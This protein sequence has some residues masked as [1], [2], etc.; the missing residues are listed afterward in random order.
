MNLPWISIITM[1]P[2][3]G[4]ALVFCL[5]RSRPQWHKI[6]TFA[7][8]LLVLIFSIPLFT[9]FCS[10]S[11]FQFVE[12]RPL[13]PGFGIE[14]YLG[15]DGI[16]L[17]LVLLVTFLSP[18]VVLS[19]W[20]YI[21]HQT[22]EY[23]ACLLLLQCGMTGALA[24]MDTFLFYVFWELMLVPMFFI[25]GIWGGPRR[26]YA[27]IKFVLFTLVGSL[28]MLIGIIYL[29]WQVHDQLGIRSFSILDFFK[30]QLDMGEQ[31]W[32]FGAFALAFAIKV[33]MFPFH[34]WLPDAHV[35][36][37]TGGSVIL[38]G[39]LLKMGT[40]G[41]L[42]FVLPLFPAASHFFAPLMIILA[43]IG[44]IYGALVSLVQDDVKKLVAYSSVSHLGYVMLGIF[45]FSV[46]GIQGGIFQMLSHGL[47]T[48]A[49]F[50]I[51]GMLYERRHTRQIEEFGGLCRTLPRLAV[52]FMVTVLASAGLPGLS[53]F[54]GEFLI[55]LAAFKA[56]P[57]WGALAGTGIILGA[58]YLLWM[59]QRVMFGP[60]KKAEN[61]NLPDLSLR[62]ILVILPLVV[63][64]LFMGVYPKPILSRTEKSVEHLLEQVRS[65][66][67]FQTV[68]NPG[69]THEYR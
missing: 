34:T 20:Q 41:F 52:V 16:S 30:L 11:D 5:P 43:I 23:Y 9:G 56:W 8:T 62:E 32:L 53:G 4:F 6:I 7:I 59:F 54:V 39:V 13:V 29:S 10:T 17:F 51:V 66:S 50:L 24:A 63:M 12:R 25:I 48:G 38:A 46:Q 35:E 68:Q 67:V 37:P 2:L 18:L 69:N 14:Y 33:P 49:L 64:M 55:L 27:T 26:I 45:V 42:R 22:R 3:V 21:Q 44:I 58:V 57:V 15:I 1:L 65:K 60:L 47:C 61:K 40:Y 36:A 28:L 31:C 19:S